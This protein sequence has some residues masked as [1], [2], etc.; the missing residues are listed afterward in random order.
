V[1]RVA[2][3][4]VLLVVVTACSSPA[5]PSTASPVAV[6]SLT[7]A[8]TTAAPTAT[9]APSRHVN[10]V[11]GFAVTVPAPWRVSEC[12]SGVTRE[13]PYLGQD[14]LTWR[15]AGEEHDLGGGAD[16]GG[17]GAFTW[18]ISITAQIS[19]NTAAEFAES[20][21]GGVGDKVEATTIDGRPAIRKAS[22]LTGRVTYYVANAG[23]VYAIGLSIGFNPNDPPPPA[24]TQATFDA[25]ARSLTFLT[26]TARPT[27]SPT[28]Q[29]SPAV[30]AAVDAVAAAFAAS[31]ADKLRELMPPKCWFMSAGYASSGVLL[32]REKMADLLRTSF[33]Q[34]RKVTVESRP[35]NTDAPYVRGPFWVWSTWSAYNAPSFNPESVTQLVFDQIDGRWY[36]TGALFN[37]GSLKPAR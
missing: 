13:G 24:N 26:P 5:I 23:R 31:D 1:I 4:T 32:S 2:F 36:W 21:G 20:V 15:T 6:P 8:P 14:V 16:T 7:P 28:P 17:S 27:P 10:E 25:V 22:G 35:I 34:G 18:V 19:S 11:L 9:P 30:T 37:A 29:L 12:Q 33:A 3:A